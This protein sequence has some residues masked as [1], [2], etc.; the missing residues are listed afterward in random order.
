MFSFHI[1]RF[2]LVGLTVEF[3]WQ[4]INAQSG[5]IDVDTMLRDAADL[6]RL[7]RERGALATAAPEDNPEPTGRRAPREED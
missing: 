2:G 5:H 3:C 6:V 1:L 4:F 7:C